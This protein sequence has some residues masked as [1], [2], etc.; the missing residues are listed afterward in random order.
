LGINGDLTGIS[1]TGGGGSGAMFDLVQLDDAL[2]ELFEEV[3]KPVHPEAQEKVPIPSGLDLDQPFN[4][5]ECDAMENTF[6]S[7][8]DGDSDTVAV[9]FVMTNSEK[10]AA[11]KELEGDDDEFYNDE[12]FAGSS[13]KSKKKKKKG[14]NSDGEES[15]TAASSGIPE[16]NSFDNL[17][18]RHKENDP[19][20]L[21]SGGFGSASAVNPA[22][23]NVDSIPMVTITDDDLDVFDVKQAKV[24]KGKKGNKA[25]KKKRKRSSCTKFPNYFRGNSPRRRD[26]G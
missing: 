8:G 7:T 5:E 25:K 17:N 26:F 21:G 1:I 19:F 6:H 16:S 9:S 4:S 23:I 2:K 15:P 20:M 11:E 22:D 14:R 12:L 3:L 10:Y 18:T 24:K 13:S